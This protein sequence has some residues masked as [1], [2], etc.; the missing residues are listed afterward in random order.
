MNDIVEQALPFWQLDG[1]TYALVAARENAVFRINHKGRQFA[2]RLHRQGYRTDSEL[3]SE[4]K[5]M[6]AVANGGITVPVPIPS[7]SGKVLH[8]IDGVQVDVL[9]WLSGQ[10]ISEIRQ[11]PFDRI[12]L[13]E[14]LGATMARLHETSDAWNR[15]EAFERRAWD[16]DG[17]LGDAPLWGRFWENPQLAR[18]D[19]QLFRRFR[20]K[21][22]AAL[23][24]QS[25]HLDYGL[26]HADLVGE[27]VMLDAENIQLIDFD[28][29]G[30]GYR[31][32]EISTALLKH[33]SAPDYPKLRTALLTGYGSVR[34]IDPTLLDL[35]LAIRSATY[36]GW[37]MSRMGEE[38]AGARSERFIT[39]TRNLATRY[40]AT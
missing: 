15:P 1:A 19:Q 36:V 11:L 3:W 12:K 21:A 31:L 33:I 32:F 14:N 6:E 13:F 2:L 40:L 39:R 9:S 22:S 30:F 25:K 35:F 7:V 20:D 24:K 16:L 4:L 34:A 10:M 23:S 18:D 5:W 37:I 27:N 8:I 17:L 38:G 29:G 26:I 28:D